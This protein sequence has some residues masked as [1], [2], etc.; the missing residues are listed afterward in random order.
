MK[1]LKKTWYAH[2]L[3]FHQRLSFAVFI[4]SAIVKKSMLLF[5]LQRLLFVNARFSMLS[6]NSCD[7]NL[8]DSH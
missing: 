7:G 6:F 2:L 1:Y 3:D 5:A 8:E 4:V